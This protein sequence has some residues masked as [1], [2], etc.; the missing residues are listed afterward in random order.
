VH[1]GRKEKLCKEIQMEHK[2]KHHSKKHDQK[3]TRVDLANRKVRIGSKVYRWE[4]FRQEYSYSTSRYWDRV[5]T[6]YCQKDGK[7]VDFVPEKKRN[8]KRHDWDD[9]RIRLLDDHNRND[10]KLIKKLNIAVVEAEEEEEKAT[11]LLQK[12]VLATESVPVPESESE[13]TAEESEERPSDAG[14]EVRS[15]SGRDRHGRLRFITVKDKNGKERYFDLV[16]R[17]A[18]KFPGCVMFDYFI[19][20]GRRSLYILDKQNVRS[21]VLE[22]ARG[23][24]RKLLSKVIEDLRKFVKEQQT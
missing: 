4:D 18:S 21:L 23:M 5:S 7:K 22:Q 10:H 14:K 12:V 15:A 8:P 1:E 2:R 17:P 6:K 9:Y 13:C 19:P 16:C 11:K 3:K 24:S 20:T